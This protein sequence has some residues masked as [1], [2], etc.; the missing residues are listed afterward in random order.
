MEILDLH[1]P[2]TLDEVIEEKSRSPKNPEYSKKL[3]LTHHEKKKPEDQDNFKTNKTELVKKS[4]A[5]IEQMK[6][7]DDKKIKLPRISKS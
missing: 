4:P 2:F 7:T 5:K 6:P 1:Q 3:S